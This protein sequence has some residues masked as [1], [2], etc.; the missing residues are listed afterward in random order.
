MSVL[1]ASTRDAVVRAITAAGS[2]PVKLTP[3]AIYDIAFGLQDLAGGRLVVVQKDKSPVLA[4]RGAQQASKLTIDVAVQYKYATPNTSEIDPY[5]NAAEQIGEILL[6]KPLDTGAVCVE[7]SFPHGA[8]LQ[9]H[10]EK[11]GVFTCIVS[12]V[13]LTG[14]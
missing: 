5:Q 4:S 13:F 1:F 11:F 10:I 3:V 14:N 12:L 6:A 7:F 2:L 9:E 8:F